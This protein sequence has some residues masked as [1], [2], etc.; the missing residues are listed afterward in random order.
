[1]P[2]LRAL[3][4]CL[5]FFAVLWPA[6]APAAIYEFVFAANPDADD[7]GTPDSN[8]DVT[9][10]VRFD[11]SRFASYDL[12]GLNSTSHWVNRDISLEMRFNS[13]S[14]FL[15]DA[16]N[17][18]TPDLTI[19]E[20]VVEIFDTMSEFLDIDFHPDSPFILNNQLPFNPFVEGQLDVY[21]NQQSFV[22]FF[23]VWVNGD[24]SALERYRVPEP[25]QL[26]LV[27]I[28]LAA[29]AITRKRRNS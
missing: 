16:F 26:G 28:G 10:V 25:S 13:Q 12:A 17:P 18:A 5:S 27:G 8:L 21:D 9:Y 6:Q 20:G 22:D 14:A 19:E 4:V 1:M 23:A 11:S 29:A 2:S 7:V 24:A 15:N 3:F